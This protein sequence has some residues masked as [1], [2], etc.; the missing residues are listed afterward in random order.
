L[1]V[2][3]YIAREMDRQGTVFLGRFSHD[4]VLFGILDDPTDGVLG[5][6]CLELADDLD[7]FS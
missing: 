4:V 6:V 2:S 5:D 3:G 1:D 7:W